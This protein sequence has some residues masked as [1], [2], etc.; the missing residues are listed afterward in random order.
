VKNDII[1]EYLYHYTN[2][3]KLAM[4]LKGK[5]FRFGNLRY[6]DDI[7]E[8]KTADKQQYAKYCFASSWTD[9]K[10]ESIP[11]WKM[12]NENMNGVRIGLPSNLFP[13][14][15]IPKHDILNEL[16]RAGCDISR[17]DIGDGIKSPVPVNEFFNEHY[18]FSPSLFSGVEQI[19]I[20]YSNEEQTV[21]PMISSVTDGQL[22]VLLGSIGKVKRECWKFQREWRYMI[23]IYPESF[24]DL[25]GD[26]TMRTYNS[27]VNFC[28]E[29]PESVRTAY[30]LKCDDDKF[31]KMEIILGPKMNEGHKDI[32]RLLLKEYCPS[33]KISESTLCDKIR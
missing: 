14:Y 15:E 20:D 9:E 18:N 26:L 33:A 13:Y 11:M 3:D 1:P 19:K 27:V 24:V 32:V 12:Y 4:I 2:I 16:I 10:D 21:N 28:P 6:L 7:E 8:G 22:F 29:L 17:I 23:R 30:Y 25:W 5:N 31:A